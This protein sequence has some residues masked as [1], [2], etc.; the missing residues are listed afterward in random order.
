MTM[1]GYITQNRDLQDGE[2]RF[3]HHSDYYGM[4]RHYEGCL[5]ERGSEF[6]VMIPEQMTYSYRSGQRWDAPEYSNLLSD[7]PLYG[8]LSRGATM[9]TGHEFHTRRKTL[10][11]PYDDVYITGGPSGWY[12][13]GP[14]MGDFS[15]HVVPGFWVNVPDDSAQ[16]AEEGA[17]AI[18]LTV[19]TL[20][21]ASAAIFFGELREGLPSLIGLQLLKSRSNRIRNLGSEYLNIEFGW[22]PLVND[23][24]KMVSSVLRANETIAQYQRDSGRKVRRKFQFDEEK[25]TRVESIKSSVRPA[26]L[27]NYVD[28]FLPLFSEQ[29]GQLVETTSFYRKVWFSGAYSY[30][31]PQGDSV[32]SELARVEAL[33]NKIL[34]TRLTPEVL[35]ELAPWS[36]LSD[37]VMNVGVNISNFSSFSNDN[38][39]IR[40]AYLMRHYVL[41]HST[42]LSGVRPQRSNKP[43][44]P[45][46]AEWSTTDKVRIKATPFGFG[47]NPADFSLR[48]W[49]IL[50]ALGMTKAPDRLP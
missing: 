30:W 47:L 18:S 49:A 43:P 3:T 29:R 46:L 22:K 24:K 31:L 50:G 2:M 38:L 33:G 17:R 28:G 4:P 44:G 34:G 45:Y 23:V 13:R 21:A 5:T 42:L 14:L 36:W 6:G 35:W 15:E 12:Y 27:S 37:W 7:R 19:P 10:R 41:D 26:V 1:D 11:V 9:D 32:L 48:Q 16:L 40:H 39:V 25:G 8:G 20:P